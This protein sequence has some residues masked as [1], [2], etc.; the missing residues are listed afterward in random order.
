MKE[1]QKIYHDTGNDMEWEAIN[2]VAIEEHQEQYNLEG[3]EEVNGWLKKQE[4]VTLMRKR[5][6]ELAEEQNYTTLNE[7]FTKRL[8]DVNRYQDEK[9][10]GDKRPILKSPSAPARKPWKVE[11][12]ENLDDGSEKEE[13]GLEQEEI[14]E[15]KEAKKGE[16]DTPPNAR[17]KGKKK[18]KKK[19]RKN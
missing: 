14:M 2:L 16:K 13:E 3:Q 10:A 19:K 7:D 12:N 9:E 11:V 4:N 18:K 6:I 8:E 15:T 17:G 1:W 5:V